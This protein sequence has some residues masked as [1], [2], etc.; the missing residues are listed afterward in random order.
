MTHYALN[1]PVSLKREAE[2][3]PP[4][5]EYCSINLLCGQFRKKLLHYARNWMIPIF[6]ASLTGA[7]PSGWI[8]PVLRGTG[9]RVQT[10]VNVTP[11]IQ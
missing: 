4:V 10:I 9:I 5:R 1:L 6:P 8:T 2:K 3:W 11:Y 7:V